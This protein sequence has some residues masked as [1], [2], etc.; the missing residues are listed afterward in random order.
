MDDSSRT[1]DLTHPFPLSDQG[2]ECIEPVL[3]KFISEL[4]YDQTLL[5]SFIF[6]PQI[7]NK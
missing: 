7:R 4:N 5:Y 2:E 1:K 3:Q 6:Y